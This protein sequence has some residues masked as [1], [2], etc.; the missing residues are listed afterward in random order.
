M[1]PHAYENPSTP[2]LQAANRENVD[3]CKFMQKLGISCQPQ[4]KTAQLTNERYTLE[5]AEIG[6]SGRIRTYNPSVNSR[7]LCH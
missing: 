1:G 2:P 6:S 4:E 3:P 7:M 5:Y